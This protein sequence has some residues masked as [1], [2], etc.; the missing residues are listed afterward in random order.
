MNHRKTTTGGRRQAVALHAVEG[1]LMVY[2]NE[3]KG[4][5]SLRGGDGQ[6]FFSIVVDGH[7]PLHGVRLNNT[8]KDSLYDVVVSFRIQVSPLGAAVLC[9]CLAASALLPAKPPPR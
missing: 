9:C 4:T 1:L 2:N 5:G 6:L 3:L 7:K 8:L